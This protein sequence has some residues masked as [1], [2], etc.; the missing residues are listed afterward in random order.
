M[1]CVNCDTVSIQVIVKMIDCNSIVI[2][3]VIPYINI[4][5]YIYLKWFAN[6][7]RMKW[8]FGTLIT[9]RHKHTMRT[10]MAI[11][12][13]IF[14]HT[15]LVPMSDKCI[16]HLVTFQM[17]DPQYFSVMI[18]FL[19]AWGTTNLLIFPRQQSI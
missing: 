8:R 12:N 1:V 14:I 6:W 2:P 5:I 19:K 3:I 17:S 9:S 18:K 7:Y 15:F 13:N 4:Y 16:I 11:I 10:F